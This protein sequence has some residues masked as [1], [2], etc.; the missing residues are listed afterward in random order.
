MFGRSLQRARLMTCSLPLPKMN[1]HWKF[2]SHLFV[3]VRLLLGHIALQW[4]VVVRFTVAFVSV[5]VC[6][7]SSFHVM[8]INCFLIYW[9]KQVYRIRIRVY[10]PLLYIL[11]VQN[12]VSTFCLSAFHKWNFC[13][14]ERER[15]G[16][17]SGS[18]GRRLRVVGWE[19]SSHSRAK[20]CSKVYSLNLKKT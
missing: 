14:R 6:M 17:E 9:G 11:F 12:S 7:Y 15:G 13:V 1:G 8:S 4:F 10:F 2:E 5:H 18:N 16:R 3:Y 19:R 20:R